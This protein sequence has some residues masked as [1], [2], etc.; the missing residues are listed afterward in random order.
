MRGLILTLLILFV[1]AH[2]ACSYGADFVVVNTSGQPVE[3]SYRLKAMPPDNP[4][5]FTGVPAKLAASQLR[6]RSKQWRELSPGQLRL[7]AASRAVTVPLAP[8]EA[9]RV[10]T[11]TDYGWR[12][13]APASQDFPVAEITVAGA[14]GAITLT[15]RQVHKTFSEEL[16]GLYALTYK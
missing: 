7:N 13:D 2:A 1:A 14:G 4:F 11:V 12:D 15:G 6:D 10:A 9:L 5:W 3:V 16:S 8:G